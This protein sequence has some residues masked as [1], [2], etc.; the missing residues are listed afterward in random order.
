MRIFVTGSCTSV[1]ASCHAPCLRD[2]VRQGFEVPL[3]WHQ[4]WFRDSALLA[5]FIYQTYKVSLPAKKCTQQARCLGTVYFCLY[6]ECHKL[7]YIYLLDT[8]L[9]KP[10]SLPA[11]GLANLSTSEFLQSFTTRTLWNVWA[12]YCYHPFII[13]SP[14]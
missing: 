7:R 4:L 12:F 5:A 11:V 6:S 2:S 10:M 1:I 13:F 14:I 9:Q 3:S 8:H